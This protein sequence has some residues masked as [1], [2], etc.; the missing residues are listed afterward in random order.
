MPTDAELSGHDP[1][2]PDWESLP[3]DARRG[4]L[5]VDG[6]LV[7]QAEIPVTTPVAF[8]PG[9]LTCGANPGLPVTPYY[10]SPF[11]FTGTLHSV[12]VDVSGDLIT[13]TESEMRLAMSRQ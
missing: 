2:V 12:T 6:H 7:G 1:D 8:N 10:R 4:Q 11:R 5:Y 3:P 13:D 9:G